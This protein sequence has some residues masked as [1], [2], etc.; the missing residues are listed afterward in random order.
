R[1]LL[2]RNE[3]TAGKIGPIDVATF[4]SSFDAHL[5]YSPAQLIE[6]GVEPARADSVL[7]ASN[8][9]LEIMDALGTHHAYVSDKGL[10]DGAALE[11]YRELLAQQ[12][13]QPLDESAVA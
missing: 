9:M 6:L 2:S 3:L 11:R 4:R 8:I 7:A 1:R 10:R 5:G 12:R 13:H